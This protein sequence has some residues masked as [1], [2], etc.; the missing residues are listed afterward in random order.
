MAVALYVVGF[1]ETL[2]ELLEVNS[3]IFNHTPAVLSHKAN[4]KFVIFSL[5]H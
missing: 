2:T 1:A 5:S 3:N 4:Y